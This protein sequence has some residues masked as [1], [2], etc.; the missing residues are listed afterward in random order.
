MSIIIIR[1]RKDHS[2]DAEQLRSICFVHSMIP[3]VECS[4]LSL[5]RGPVTPE[6]QVVINQFIEFDASR[7]PTKR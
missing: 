2:Y 5:D 7:Q 6:R 1:G 3:M 4:H